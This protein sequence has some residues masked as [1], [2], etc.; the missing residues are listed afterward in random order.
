MI[1]Q[2]LFDWYNI[3]TG[4]DLK[5]KNICPK[6]Y[7]TILIDQTGSCYLCECQAWLPQ[8]VGNLHKNT[9]EE[10]FSSEMAKHMRE[11]VTDGTYRYC[12]SSQCPWI[13]K[14]MVE[15]HSSK[16]AT[17]KTVRLAIDNSC[18]LFCPSCRTEKI[19]HKKGKMFNLKMQLADKI[20]DFLKTQDNVLIHIGADGDP[21]AS[22]VY[23]Y[24]MRNVPDNP[25]FKF[26]FQ[27]NGLLLKKMFARLHN[28]VDRIQELNISIDGASTET[29]EKLRRGGKFDLMLSNLD[30]IK[31]YSKKFKINLHMVVQKDN[32][33]EMEDMVAL[34]KK[35]NVNKI[36]FN[37]IQDWNTTSNFQSTLPPEHEEKFLEQYHK[38]RTYDNVITWDLQ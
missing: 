5:I 38:V 36:W 23:R 9:L 8:S 19:F 37:K 13:Q 15:N 31:D 2:R 7:D 21:F 32:W 25:T 20:I 4:K 10:I 26:N 16:M 12:N 1:N 3:D 35:Y 11:S 22:L 33:H 6:P 28:V 27:T 29:Y 17:V 24:F 14:D 18:N 30:Y 34:G